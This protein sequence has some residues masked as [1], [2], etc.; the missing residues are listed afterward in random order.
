MV[1]FLAVQ[2]VVR[3]YVQRDSSLHC[4]MCLCCHIRDRAVEALKRQV[5]CAQRTDTGSQSVHDEL[6]AG[7]F[8]QIFKYDSGWN[9]C[10]YS[11]ALRFRS[12]LE[13]V[14]ATALDDCRCL[15]NREE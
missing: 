11:A 8:V 7:P 5:N 15:G 14:I 12:H 13:C 10:M 6:L 2:I 9:T 3:T 4:R 1:T